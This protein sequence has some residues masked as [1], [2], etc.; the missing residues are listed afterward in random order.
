MLAVLEHDEGVGDVGRHRVGGDLRGADLGERALDFRRGLERGFELFLH[1]HRLRQAGARNA[2]CVQGDV[3][4]VQARDEFRTHARG[5]PAAGR[6]QGERERQQR[7]TRPQ[8]QR[9]QRCIAAPRPAHQRVVVLR[10]RAAEQQGHRRRHEGERQ[11]QRGGQRGDH[12]DRHRVEHFPFHAGQGEDR[13]VHGRDDADAEQRG[14]DDFVGGL[15]HDFEP[16]ALAQGPAAGGGQSQS[17]QAVL[18]DDHRA[19]HDQPEVERAQAHQVGRGARLHHAGEGHQ[20]GQWNHRRGQQRGADV[21]EQRKQHHHDQQR[22]FEQVLLHRGQGLVDQRGA[23]VDHIDGDARRQAAPGLVELFGDLLRHRAAVLAD[24]HEHRAQHHF[25]AV[26]RGRAGAQLGAD[27]KLRH[28]ADPH[29]RAAALRNHDTAQIGQRGRLSGHAQ[30]LLLAVALDVTGATVGIV[31]P[32][33]A[34]HVVEADAVSQQAPRIGQDLELLAVTADAVD[35]HHAGYLQ[36]LRAQDPVLR[37]A[38]VG[39]RD[40]RVV[41]VARAGRGVHRPHED[42]AKT[43]GDRPKLRLKAGGQLRF[44]RLQ[45]VGDQLPREVDVGGVVEHHRHLRQPVARHRA[46]VR[47]LRQPGHG[48]F[49][50]KGHALFGFRR[51]VAGRLGVDLHLHVGDVRHRVDRQMLE[52]PHAKSGQGEHQHQHQATAVD[53]KTKQCFEHGMSLTGR[54]RRA[55]AAPASKNRTAQ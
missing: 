30:Q 9:Q 42:F 22:A 26:L 12:G 28:V 35:L 13:Q 54:C 39:R 7:K 53:G 45:A 18:H 41:G 21:A 29:R 33:R 25:L 17:A 5:Q 2:Q 43:G 40:R 4:F 31:G 14:P 6:D 16:F 8:R 15:E 47:Q 37:L 10:H 1:L 24:Q 19:V 51:R 50:G 11:Q 49:H 32:H 44:D 46:R 52:A 38:Q 27:A 34:G 3:A 23:V 48:G 36:Q 20:H 55:A